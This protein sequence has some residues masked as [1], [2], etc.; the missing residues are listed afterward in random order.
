MRGSILVLAALLLACSREASTAHPGLPLQPAVLPSALPTEAGA[1]VHAVADAAPT[2]AAVDLSR[3]RRDLAE[4]A[5]AVRD[6]AAAEIRKALATNP[7]AGERP[8]AYWREKIAGI[9][10]GLTPDQLKEQ[11]G[12]TAEGGGGATQSYRL[13]DHWIVTALFTTRPA[14][15]LREMGKLV[16]V[17]RAVWVEPPKGHTGA[18]KTYDV[19]GVVRH[20]I[21]YEKGAYTRFRAFHDNGQLSYEQQYAG[22]K[23]DGDET[24]FHPNGAKAYEIHHKAG[25][26][27][28]KWVHWFANGKLESEQ[29]YVDGLLDGS[30]MNWREDGTR[31]SRIDYRKGEETGQAA[32]DE[33][34][35]LLYARGTAE[36]P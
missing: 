28:G 2:L 4:P 12:A 17:P 16:R 24:G 23:I 3:P 15:V 14:W 5:Q 20:E 11:L 26:N 13:D 22:G 29:T 18:W 35:K 9:K 31:S 34:G 1:A 25:K 36:K 19:Q 10:P 30:T 33:K 21:D 27:V 8:E 6:A 32:W 7:G